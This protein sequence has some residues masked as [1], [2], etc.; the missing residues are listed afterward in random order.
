[1]SA[2]PTLV[3][4]QSLSSLDLIESE[5]HHPT[6]PVLPDLWV[7]K[8][9]GASLGTVASLPAVIDGDREVSFTQLWS[10]IVR[11]AAAFTDAGLLAGDRMALW[12][13]NSLD[14]IVACVGAQAVGAIVV[15]INTRLKG[16]EAAYILNRTRARFLVVSEPFLGVDYNAV[17]AAQPTP[18]LERTLSLGPDWEAFLAAAKP[19]AEIEARALAVRP[20]DACDI[21]FTSGTTGD[22]KGV[23]AGHAQSCR[24]FRSWVAKVGLRQGDRYLVVNP[25]FHSFGYKAGWLACLMAGATI[26]PMKTF[27]V[28]H[29]IE[30]VRTHR[31]T[32]LPGPPAIFQTLLA[33]DLAGA[34]LGSIRLSVTG[35]ASIP[36]TLIERMRT[37][38]GIESVLTGYG[39]TETC[40]VVSMSSAGDPADIVARTCGKPIDG[41]EVR[42]I[43]GAGNPV[44][45][46]VEGEV[47]VRG[48]NVMQGYFEAPEATAEAID[49]EGWL[50]TGDVGRLDEDGRLTI[51]DRLKDMYISGGFNCYPAEI[52]KVLQRHP[53]VAFAAVIGVPDPRLGE[54]GKAFVA[55]VSGRTLDPDALLAWARENMANYKAPR[56]VEVVAALPLNAAGKVQK[57]ELRRIAKTKG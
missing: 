10:L 42:C 3:T 40:G 36:P 48:F 45:A 29:L 41:V 23:I 49:A 26:Y 39:L 6:V 31:I 16:G 44:P 2:N 18:H 24:T 35:A 55:P 52:E 27:D 32:V 53:D 17:L 56:S 25:F 43:D 12:A 22:P 9:G 46:G 7:V 21:M 34:D 33:S 37:D 57:F 14:W 11:A 20:E 28:T 1:M 50:R 4:G 47:V 15:P 13:P 8:V 5:S 19:G 51:T 54:V 38:L 30:L